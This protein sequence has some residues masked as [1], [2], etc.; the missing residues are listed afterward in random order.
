MITRACFGTVI[1]D[2]R[3]ISGISEFYIEILSAIESCVAMN[4]KKK[5]KFE[6]NIFR[7]PGITKDQ[8][9]SLVFKIFF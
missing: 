1:K 3:N 4:G 5:K 8:Q 9:N 2:F 7:I 6:I